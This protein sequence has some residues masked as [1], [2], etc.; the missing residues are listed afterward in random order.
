MRLA[1]WDGGMEVDGCGEVF[2]FVCFVIV[3]FLLFV[4]YCEQVWLWQI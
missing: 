2:Y 1:L 3:S 4:F